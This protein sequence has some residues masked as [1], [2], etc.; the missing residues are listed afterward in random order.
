VLLPACFSTAGPRLRLAAGVVPGEV[1]S[2]MITRDARIP[3]QRAA[4]PMPDLAAAGEL[5]HAPG[6]VRAWLV[7]DAL[8][9]LGV[10]ALV[11]AISVTIACQPVL[12]V[13][14]SAPQ[15]AFAMGAVSSVVAL[16]LVQVEVLRFRALGRPL[17]LLV[18][19][20]FGMCAIANACMAA[21]AP[22]IALGVPQLSP[23]NSLTA[24]S[25]VSR[26]LAYLTFGLAVLQSGRVL[27]PG[28]RRAPTI[29]LG[30][31][32]GL[33]VLA[34]GSL[35]AYWLGPRLPAALDAQA[36]AALDIDPTVPD[37]LEDQAGWLLAANG[38]LTVL[39][40]V[41]AY[42]VMVLAHH[43]ADAHLRVLGSG[44]SLLA[45]SQVHALLFP[46]GPTG[47]VSISDLFQLG[48]YV[49]LLFR[50]VSRV[51][52]DLAERASTEERL[53][54]SRE[55][56]D[57]LAQQL[58]ALN[59]RLS[60]AIYAC[61]DTVAPSLGRNL[62]ASRT[63]ART[64]LL[65]ARQ[66]ITAL[67]SGSMAWQDFIDA[68]EAFCDESSQ[69][70]GVEI[71]LYVDGTL[72]ALDTEL[73]VEVTRM[74]NETISNAV[75]HGHAKRIDVHVLAETQPTR[76]ALRVHDDGHGLPS[77]GHP[78]GGGLGLRSLAERMEGRGGLVK[79]ESQSTG[80]TLVDIELPLKT[81]DRRSA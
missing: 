18:G 24:M 29:A 45:L 2:R 27:S 72:A 11:A 13:A 65:E 26:A 48:A 60:Q 7:R 1:D 32:A 64:A 8:V 3:D 47:Y 30:L 9:R 12:V 77:G 73:V 31:A 38:T 76:L 51:T 75:R 50:L 66:A 53:R 6:W 19:V 42:R 71:D 23:L 58:N 57:G 79:V 4:P 36:A 28:C 52:D 46:P 22:A 49:A 14:I 63:L 55:L 54:L 80:G 33:L 43:L 34:V 25:V 62:Q 61:P 39:L 40:V 35:C 59:L 16:A 37:L 15:V 69:N 56:H 41:A 74:L 70:H 78:S 10:W 44:L 67:R 5:G 81:R 20:G 17:D 21:L 68:L